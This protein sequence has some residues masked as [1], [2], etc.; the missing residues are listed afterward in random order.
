[1]VVWWVRVVVQV[2]IPSV[3]TPGNR[4]TTDPTL[5]SNAPSPLPCLQ[6]IMYRLN[7]LKHPRCP[8]RCDKRRIIIPPEINSVR[9]K[10]K[11]VASPSACEADVR[12]REIRFLSNSQ[13]RS[14][15][16]HSPVAGATCSEISTAAARQNG[17]RSGCTATK[18]RGA[19]NARSQQETARKRVLRE[20]RESQIH[21][22]SYG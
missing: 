22:C 13:N 3:F 17:F 11:K 7:R 12:M 9:A 6:L 18:R 8:S 1:M 5:S 2:Q 16:A 14:Y 19:C 10:K 20:Y 4:V 21:C 15:T